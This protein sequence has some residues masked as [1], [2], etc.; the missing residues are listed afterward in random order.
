[1]P[2]MSA[3][4]KSPHRMPDDTPA[5]LAAA[6]D[7]LVAALDAAAASG[8]GDASTSR[9]VAD[10]VQSCSSIARR[11]NVPPEKLIVALK[12]RLTRSAERVPAHLREQHFRAL[13]TLAIENYFRS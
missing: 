8:T 5:E 10:A 1:M 7:Q 11:H 6:L 13:V 12:P 4:P 2:P 3:E 9:A